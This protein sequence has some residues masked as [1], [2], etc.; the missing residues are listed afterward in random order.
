MR[1]QSVGKARPS[2]SGQ[3]PSIAMA[4]SLLPRHPFFL[5]IQSY[6]TR[7]YRVALGIWSESERR[8]LSAS[9]KHAA[10]RRL[11]ASSKH[12]WSKHAAST[13]LVYRDTKA[14]RLSLKTLSLPLKVLQGRKRQTRRARQ[15]RQVKTDKSDRQV[16]A[17]SATRP[18]PHALYTRS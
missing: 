15:D 17:H 5:A 8:R 14:A 18:Q 12:A 6:T 1:W 10:R 3:W 16:S 7:I 9:S 4:R 11:C 13:R 2:P